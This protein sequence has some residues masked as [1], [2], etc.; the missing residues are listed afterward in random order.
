M[1]EAGTGDGVAWT[2][3]SQ[4]SPSLSRHL[5]NPT[6]AYMTYMKSSSQ[7]DLFFSNYQWGF[8][9][10]PM[11]LLKGKGVWV[12]AKETG[13]LLRFLFIVLRCWMLTKIRYSRRCDSGSHLVRPGL[14]SVRDQRWL[15]ISFKAA[16]C[17]VWI[18]NV[19]QDQLEKAKSSVAS[20]TVGGVSDEPFALD[21]NIEG[22]LKL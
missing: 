17:G 19:G 20:R 1:V 10:L 22:Q 21:A 7:S 16:K 13:Q 6:S 18:G 3:H 15:C 11:P 14:R 2:P 8:V 4:T 12:S 5:Q 9:F